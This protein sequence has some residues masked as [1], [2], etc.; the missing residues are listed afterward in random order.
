MNEEQ[1]VALMSSAVSSQ[2]WNN[3][4]DEVKRACN[5]YPNFW[6]GSIIQSGLAREVMS[7]FGASPEI[8]IISF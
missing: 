4:C 3:K 7:K 8:R 6:F 5:G 2:D 1:V